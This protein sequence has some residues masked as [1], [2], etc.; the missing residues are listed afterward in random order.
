MNRKLIIN[1]TK[2]QDGSYLPTDQSRLKKELFDKVLGNAKF[3]V[4]ITVTHLGRLV[5]NIEYK[6]K[7]LSSWTGY[8]AQDRKDAEQYL[9]K[10]A[11]SIYGDEWSFKLLKNEVMYGS[12]KVYGM[13]CTDDELV[14]QVC[15]LLENVATVEVNKTKQK[16]NKSTEGSKTEEG[17]NE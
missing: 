10:V 7:A 3:P 4:T 6:V 17:T 1:P 16:K 2:A 14:Q 12:S 9:S 11:D 13:I 8:E 15:K 5:S